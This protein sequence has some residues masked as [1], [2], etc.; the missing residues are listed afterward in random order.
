MSSI[1]AAENQQDTLRDALHAYGENPAVSEEQR[2]F[3]EARPLVMSFINSRGGVVR[4][5]SEEIASECMVQIFERAAEFQSAMCPAKWVLA[6]LEPIIER[7]RKKAY[8]SILNRAVSLWDELKHILTLPVIEPPPI[9]QESETRYNRLM[10]VRL[11]LDNDCQVLLAYAFDERQT[12]RQIAEK[13]AE[14]KLTLGFRRTA[15]RKRKTLT[16]LEL[17]EIIRLRV[18]YCKNKGV[19]QGFCCD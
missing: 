7:H 9:S 13:V 15:P 16:V 2:L 3:Y 14:G 5:D 10:E 4:K 12:P 19:T 17:T 1:C 11:K 18:H 6:L 8:G